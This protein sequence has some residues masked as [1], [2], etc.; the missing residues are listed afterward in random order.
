[1]LLEHVPLRI[2]WCLSTGWVPPAHGLHLD[3][4][5]ARVI[6]DRAM[7]GLEV[8]AGVQLDA[9][10]F[11]HLIADLPFGRFTAPNG[12]WV[13]QASLLHADVIASERRLMTTKTPV[14]DIATHTASGA[15]SA[16]GGAKVD[17]RRGYYKAG[18]ATYP[19]ETV[20]GITAWC[21]GDPDRIA[22]LL[23]D[24]T[25]LGTKTRLGHGLVRE[26]DGQPFDMVEDTAAFSLWQQRNMPVQLPGFIAF[27]GP[28]RSPYWDRSKATMAWRPVM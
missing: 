20:R 12:Q 13:W 1:M 18:L 5:L 21:V 27:A 17:T 22:D 3:G 19:V 9:A 6:V 11:E 8:P 15:L 28:L 10:Y 26:V 25:H 23:G 16:K 2:D 4:L 14:H 24:I 7:A